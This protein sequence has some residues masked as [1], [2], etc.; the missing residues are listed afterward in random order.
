MSLIRFFDVEE[1]QLGL[2][3]SQGKPPRKGD[4]VVFR[5]SFY[6][7]GSDKKVLDAKDRKAFESI[8][9]VKWEVVSVEHYY[10]TS[11]WGVKH[12]QDTKEVRVFLSRN[13]K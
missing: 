8:S 7:D 10:I 12:K 4:V 13:R 9:G 2:W 1:P 6:S 3:M 11:P 5:F